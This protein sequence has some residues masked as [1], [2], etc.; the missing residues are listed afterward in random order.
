MLA[1]RNISTSILNENLLAAEVLKWVQ[2]KG[3]TAMGL[4]MIL[5]FLILLADL[6]SF[7]LAL[8]T[9]LPLF[10]GL[11][12]TGAIMA[13][14]HVKL[15]FINIIMLPTIVGIMI[16]HC[17]F[18]THHILDYS[19]GQTIKS[20][21]E[22]GSAIIMSALT[23]LAGYSSLNIAHHAGIRSISTIMEIGIITCTV[24]ALFM[25][26]ALFELETHRLIP[27]KPREAMKL[28][29]DVTDQ[30]NNDE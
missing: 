20:L 12:L 25:L 9:F 10:T 18:L 23:T 13:A 14:F 2:E 5:V 21:Q 8:K 28:K 15:N 22:T 26:P 7:R 27:A 6:K 29:A 19:K 3:P 30:E 16:D 17:I 1:E 24:C 11:V 4:A